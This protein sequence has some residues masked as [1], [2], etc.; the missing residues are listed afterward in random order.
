MLLWYYV[1]YHVFYARMVLFDLNLYINT[2]NL[3]QPQKTTAAIP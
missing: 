3:R 2:S 1:L